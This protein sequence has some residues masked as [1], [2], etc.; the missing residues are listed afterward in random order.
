[1]FFSSS[2]GCL[3]F[4]IVFSNLRQISRGTHPSLIPYINKCSCYM[5]VGCRGVIASGVMLNLVHVD[6]KIVRTLLKTLR[7]SA[8]C[9]FQRLL[10]FEL[11]LLCVRVYVCVYVFCLQKGSMIICIKNLLLVVGCLV[12]LLSVVVVVVCCMVYFWFVCIYLR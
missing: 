2:G 7:V 10:I 12:F 9:S 3:L 4:N 1:M 11:W 6:V 8:S 5:F